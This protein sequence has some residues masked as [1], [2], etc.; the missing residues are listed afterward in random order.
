MTFQK[1]YNEIALGSFTNDQL[2]ELAE[3]IRYRRNQ[4]LKANKRQLAVGSKVK[5]TGRDGR[6]VLGEVTKINR[7]YVI[8]KEQPNSFNGGIFG[9]NWRVPGAMLEAV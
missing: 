3:A 7:K 2:N 5:F 6:T 4:I 1:I 9:T 8:V